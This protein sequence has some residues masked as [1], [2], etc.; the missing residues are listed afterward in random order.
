MVDEPSDDIAFEQ[1]QS[2][3][4]QVKAL[5]AED[6]YSAAG[7]QVAALQQCLVKLFNDE[8]FNADLFLATSVQAKKQQQ[9]LIEVDNFL[10]NDIEKLMTV[11]EKIKVELSHCKTVSKMKKA[12]GA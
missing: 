2:L 12:Y 1:V 9:L 10:T 3:Y 5:L 6:D 4:L 8:K 11:A 7:E